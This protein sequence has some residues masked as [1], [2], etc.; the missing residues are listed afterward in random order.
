MHERL[1]TVVASRPGTLSLT[2]R[3]GQLDQAYADLQ[4]LVG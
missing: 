2:T 1:I 4:A 3:D